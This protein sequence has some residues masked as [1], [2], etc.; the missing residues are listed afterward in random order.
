MQWTEENQ[1][2]RAEEMI[3][4]KLDYTLTK[5]IRMFYYAYLILYLLQI[6]TD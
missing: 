4:N 5:S 3:F 1:G 2:K 6:G